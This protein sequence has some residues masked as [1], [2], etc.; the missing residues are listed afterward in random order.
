MKLSYL[1]MVF[2][3][4]VLAGC[5]GEEDGNDPSGQPS[6]ADWNG[7]FSER[8]TTFTEVVEDRLAVLRWREN[9]ETFSGKLTSHGVAG[10]RRV[11][12]YLDGKKHGLC[13]MVDQAGARTETNYREGLEHGSHVMFGRDGKERF[14]WR[15]D[16]GKMMKE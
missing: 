7:T 10:E 4:L 14:R 12:R 2:L 13:I 6:S 15:Y 5:G 9:N 3:V 8:D 16:N 11:F 1:N